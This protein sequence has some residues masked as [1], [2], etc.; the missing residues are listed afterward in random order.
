MKTWYSLKLIT[1]G[2]PEA[3]DD[4]Q[5]L[6]GPLVIARPP[7][8]HRGP[9]PPPPSSPFSRPRIGGR[10]RIFFSTF[11]GAFDPSELLS[12]DLRSRLYS[13]KMKLGVVS[14]SSLNENP[15]GGMRVEFSRGGIKHISVCG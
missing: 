4:M 13:V 15:V 7:A 11:L 9:R 14:T 10:F 2:L 6:H 8:G 5:L 1:K 3:D 12:R